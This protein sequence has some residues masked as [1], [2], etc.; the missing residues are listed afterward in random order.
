[1][2]A[3]TL[4]SNGKIID[5]GTNP[6]LFRRLYGHYGRNSRSTLLACQQ[7]LLNIHQQFAA[8]PATGYR[9]LIKI[10]LFQ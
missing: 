10:K 4:K 5:L 3:N 8:K 6:G 2:S 7:V 1:M 9:L